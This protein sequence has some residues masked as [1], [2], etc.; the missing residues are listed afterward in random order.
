VLAKS[1]AA[2]FGGDV[3]ITLVDFVVISMIGG[4]VSSV[5]VLGLTLAVAAA[6]VRRGWD[7]DNVAAPLVTAAGDMVTLPA[8]FLATFLI[9]IP[10]VTVVVAVLSAALGLVALFM[11]LRSRLPILRR[12]VR[13]SVPVLVAAGTIDIGAGLALDGQFEGDD[14]PFQLYPALLVLV[15]PFLEDTGALGS[16]LS[17][18]LSS[19]LHLGVIEPRSRPQRAARTDF[20]LILMLALPVFTLVAVSAE[21]ASIVFG[22]PTPGPFNMLGVAL[23]GGLMA[24]VVG[25]LVAYYGT[26]ATYRLGLDPDN[27]GVPLLTA[28]MDFVGAFSL[29]AAIAILHIG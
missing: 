7:L 24:T 4:I 21:I 26:V 18:R 27:Y 3:S 22:R 25:V 9:D 13:E 16:V 6:S 20:F 2:A 14:S 1:A 23:L 10:G 11:S 5:F 12:I 29:I 8:L 28:S 19:K 15:P 17:A